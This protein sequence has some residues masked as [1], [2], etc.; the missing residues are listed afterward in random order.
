MTNLRLRAASIFGLVAVIG[1]FAVANLIPQET[2]VANPWLP[3]QGLRL[4]LDLQGGI[5]WVLGVELGAAE[6]RE[7]GYQRSQLAEYLEDEAGPGATVSLDEETI[8]VEGDAEAQALALE[9]ASDRGI[10]DTVATE[11]P[12]FQLDDAWQQEVRE[13]TVCKCV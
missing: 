9:F 12:S 5:H 2:R 3:D 8:V 1:Y 13:V 11:P 4:G 6:A 7:L 10:F